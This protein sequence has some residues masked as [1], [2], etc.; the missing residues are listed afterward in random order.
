VTS[1]SNEVTLTCRLA[2][3]RGLS[4]GFNVAMFLN[5]IQQVSQHAIPLFYI[6]EKDGIES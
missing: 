6:A 3:V 4:S 2:G 1:D 5:N